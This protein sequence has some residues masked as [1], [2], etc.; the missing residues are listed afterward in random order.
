MFRAHERER[1]DGVVD[2]ARRDGV[3]RDLE[4]HSN[5]IDRFDAFEL[6]LDPS[7]VARE[8]ECDG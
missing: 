2:D 7:N 4:R 5:E 3:K 6:A 8:K 1:R